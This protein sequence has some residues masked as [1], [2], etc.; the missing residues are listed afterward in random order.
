MGKK[1][2]RAQAL[3]CVQLHSGRS[4]NRPLTTVMARGLSPAR[5]RPA[6]TGAPAA[7]P[8]YTR[9]RAHAR[10]TPPTVIS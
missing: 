6:T 1:A 5:L 4:R 10:A 9:A 2:H 8:V 3:Y 7:D